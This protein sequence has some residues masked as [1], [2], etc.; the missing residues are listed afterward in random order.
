MDFQNFFSWKLMKI[1]IIFLKKK[2]SKCFRLD[3]KL[4]G[5][6]NFCLIWHLSKNI[7]NFG[8]FDSREKFLICMKSAQKT[9]FNGPRLKHEIWKKSHVTLFTGKSTFTDFFDYLTEIN[10]KS[11]CSVLPSQ[12]Q[13]EKRLIQKIFLS[14]IQKKSKNVLVMLHYQNL[15]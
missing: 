8:N 7:A 1:L 13:Y 12:W 4:A 6:R 15:E 3:V 2:L 5:N 14:F 11:G 10:M 9:E